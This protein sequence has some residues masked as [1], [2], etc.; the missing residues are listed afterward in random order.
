MMSPLYM[1]NSMAVDDLMMQGAR[2]SAAMLSND[3]FVTFPEI[4]WK[5]MKW[6]KKK[7]NIWIVPVT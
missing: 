1:V 5:I 4:C 2:A 3:S 7:N 6:R